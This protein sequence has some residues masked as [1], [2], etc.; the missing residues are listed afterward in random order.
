MPID[1]DFDK[2]FDMLEKIKFRERKQEHGTNR[3]N[4]PPYR[5]AIFGRVNARFKGWRDLSSDSIKYPEVYAELKKLGDAIV[6]FK[7]TSIQL[8]RQLVCPR[9]TDA[10]NVG[11][12]VLLSFGTYKGQSGFIYIDGKKYNAY[13]NPLMFD[14]SKLEHWN[15]PITSGIKYS[16]VYFRC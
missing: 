4:F 15:T 11:A 6:P 7:W 13:K 14:G 2:L 3:R 16:L 12:S 9:H 1:Y 8:N 10:A 5:G